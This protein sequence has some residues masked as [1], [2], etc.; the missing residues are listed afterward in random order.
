MDETIEELVVFDPL[1]F[2][3]HLPIC[4]EPPKQSRVAR[5]LSGLEVGLNF[6]LI[7]LSCFGVK[8]KNVDVLCMPQGHT[9]VI[10]RQH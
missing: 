7:C 10:T 3:V 1:M 5:A 4:D 2:L 8:H 6:N 9:R